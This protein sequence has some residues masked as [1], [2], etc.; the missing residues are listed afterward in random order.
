MS[1]IGTLYDSYLKKRPRQSR[2]RSVVEAVL[3]AATRALHKGEAEELTVQDVAE[4]AGIGIG[5]L[6]D[7]FR[8]RESVMAA[9]AAKV[10]DDN[11]IAFEAMLEKT[12][13]A[14][15]REAVTVIVDHAMTTGARNFSD[16]PIEVSA[17]PIESAQIHDEICASVRCAAWPAW[18]IRTSEL[19]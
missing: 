7:Y 11:L 6:Y 12:R 16:S 1:R 9:V 2:S 8:D 15:L 13:Q 10:T 19:V 3:V 18:N 17:M 4:S 5:S 14:P